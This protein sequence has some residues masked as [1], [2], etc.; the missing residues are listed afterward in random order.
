MRRL[1]V[2]AQAS[3][4]F[5]ARHPG[6]HPIEYHEIEGAFRQQQ[7][8]FLAACGGGDVESTRPEV[9]IKQ[10]DERRIVFND[11]DLGGHGHH[12]AEDVNTVEAVSSPLGRSS[13]ST[14]P[15]TR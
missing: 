15:V 11:E 10:C 5:D 4:E 7:V 1:A 3:A 2:A 6:E 8:A 9:V 14:L 13:T 12:R